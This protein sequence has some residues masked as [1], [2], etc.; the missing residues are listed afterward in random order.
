[1]YEMG[2]MKKMI[3]QARWSITV[4]KTRNAETTQTNLN[5]QWEK[6]RLFC[7]L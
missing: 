6:L 4:K 3:I 5:H 7:D 2:Y 1:M